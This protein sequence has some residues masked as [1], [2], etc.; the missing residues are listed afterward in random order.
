MR[1]SYECQ[2][3]GNEAID[4]EFHPIGHP[5]SRKCEA[6]GGVLRRSV[7]FSIKRGMREHFNPTVGSYVSGERQFKDGLKRASESASIQTGTEHD[8]QPV[9]LRDMDALGVTDEGLE[10][11]RKVRRDTG[12]DPAPTTVYL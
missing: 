7:C 11:T 3:C 5:H 8:Y 4:T 12:L 1:Y 6:C 10:H 9:D 2:E